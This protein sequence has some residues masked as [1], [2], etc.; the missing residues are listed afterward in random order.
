LRSIDLADDLVKEGIKG[1][2]Y[3]MYDGPY[4]FLEM[5]WSSLEGKTNYPFFLLLAQHHTERILISKLAS[6]GT[7]VKWEHKAVSIVAGDGG[8]TVGFENGSTITA[9]YVVG[10]DGSRSS[11]GNC[12]LLSTGLTVAIDSNSSGIILH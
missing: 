1:I 12:R 11:V 5:S 7:N 3:Q 9:Q 10:A 4:R 6:L 8:V 2:G